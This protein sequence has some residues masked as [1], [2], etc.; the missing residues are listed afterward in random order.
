MAIIKMKIISVGKYMAR[1]LLTHCWQEYKIVQPLWKT[2]WQF[3][4]N[5]I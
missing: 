3:L 2:V 4:K 5:K 1:T